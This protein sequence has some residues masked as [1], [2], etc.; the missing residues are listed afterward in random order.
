MATMRVI[1]LIVGI[2]V[3]VAAD[4]TVNNGASFGGWLHYLA[5]LMR[6]SGVL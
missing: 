1:A 4:M 6:T 3:F 5:T 2:F